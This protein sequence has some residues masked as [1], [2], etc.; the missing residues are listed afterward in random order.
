MSLRRHL[1]IRTFAKQP[2]QSSNTRPINKFVNGYTNNF[3]D[4]R[5]NSK[6]IN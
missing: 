2:S 4:T 5:L 1:Q 3:V 6:T